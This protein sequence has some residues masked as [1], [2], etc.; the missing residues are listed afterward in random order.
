MLVDY[1]KRDQNKNGLNKIGTFFFKAKL[2]I[3]V[4]E[5]VISSW[6]FF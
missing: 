3:R 2:G 4:A 5:C 6:T 1:F